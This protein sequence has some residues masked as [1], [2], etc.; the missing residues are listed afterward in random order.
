MKQSQTRIIPIT[1]F[2]RA[3]FQKWVKYYLDHYCESGKYRF[4]EQN[5]I[6]LGNITNYFMGIQAEYDLNK[7]LWLFGGV[8]IGKT[9]VMSAFKHALDLRFFSPWT[10]NNFAIESAQNLNDQQLRDIDVLNK[11]AE[12]IPD[13]HPAGHKKP[14]WFHLCI[15][16]LGTETSAC[17]LYTS[18]SPR[19]P[20]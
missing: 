11:Y 14:N 18:P 12:N 7:G 15:D 19:D 9:L 10:K 1:E 13:K 8:G 2:S 20:H 6:V 5:K 4:T 16:D 3:Q 17:L